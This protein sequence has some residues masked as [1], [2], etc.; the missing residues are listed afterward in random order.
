MGSKNATSVLSSPQ[1]YLWVKEVVNYAYQRNEAVAELL[2]EE[3]DDGVGLA[4]H[5]EEVQLRNRFR[6][7]NQPQQSRWKQLNVSVSLKLDFTNPSN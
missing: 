1:K 3:V 4:D 2:L 7:W 6:L 5:V